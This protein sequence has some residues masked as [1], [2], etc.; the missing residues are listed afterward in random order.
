MAVIVRNK[1]G[2][3]NYEV[4]E[5]YTAGLVLSGPEV[6]AVKGG[7]ISLK[8]S[9]VTIDSKSEVWLANCHISPYKPASGHQQGYQP[10]QP[11]KLLLNKKEISSLI[12]KSKQKG[13]TIIPIS[14]YTSRRLIKVEIGLAR[15]K[16]QI[17]KRDSI[18]K[19]EIDREIRRTLKR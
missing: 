17:D 8:G 18:R 13:L 11:R 2:L 4:L 16:T 3:F 7:Q 15:G 6:K 14:V 1:E 12:G 19:R 5:K 9:Y 10:D